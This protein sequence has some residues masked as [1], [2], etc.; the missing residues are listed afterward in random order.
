MTIVNTPDSLQVVI[1]LLVDMKAEHVISYRLTDAEV[2]ALKTLQLPGEKSVS[3]TAKRLFQQSLGLSKESST[4]EFTKVVQVD[5]IV[6]KLVDAIVDTESTFVDK[7]V[8]SNRFKDL[9]E[10]QFALVMN[11]INQK[12]LEQE[13]RIESLEKPGA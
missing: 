8:D 6:D 7:L 9:L 13:E 10:D 12:F 5:N 3:I 11:S 1:S 4:T 2:E